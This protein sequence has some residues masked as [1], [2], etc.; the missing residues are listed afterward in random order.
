MT[1]DE[2]QEVE[3]LLQSVG[4]QTIGAELLLDADF[5][6]TDLTQTKQLLHEVVSVLAEIIDH[7]V[8]NMLYGPDVMKGAKTLLAMAHYITCP[9]REQHQETQE[10][11]TWPQS[12]IFGPR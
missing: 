12:P 6:I 8:L 3:A 2:R 11:R 9:H 7:P 1:P 10:E 4:K 5:Q